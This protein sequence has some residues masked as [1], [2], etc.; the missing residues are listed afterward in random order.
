MQEDYKEPVNST[1]AAAVSTSP[2]DG[3]QPD[4]KAEL[5]K[6]LRQWFNDLNADD[7]ATALAFA[8]GRVFSFLSKGRSSLS[9]PESDGSAVSENVIPTT[10]VPVV[11][12]QYK[13]YVVSDYLEQFFEKIH[14]FAGCA[15]ADPNHLFFVSTFAVC[16]LCDLCNDYAMD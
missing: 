5:T 16:F 1:R 6:E 3:N 9:P 4:P 2:R 13:T 11:G 12:G 7:K 15:D 10:D 14:F 8:G